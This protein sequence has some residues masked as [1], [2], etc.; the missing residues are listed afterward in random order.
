MYEYHYD[1]DYQT[2][3]QTKHGQRM[4]SLGVPPSDL[5]MLKE[6]LVNTLKMLEEHGSTK[7]PNQDKELTHETQ[8]RSL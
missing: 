1:H 8:A 6:V 4:R 5:L 3:V 7:Q 2:I